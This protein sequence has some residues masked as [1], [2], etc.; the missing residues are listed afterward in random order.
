MTPN[1]HQA[2]IDYLEFSLVQLVEGIA[3]HVKHEVAQQLYERA[4]AVLNDM[5]DAL[6]HQAELDGPPIPIKSS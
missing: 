4:Y 2:I 5:D 6:C 3:P 1:E